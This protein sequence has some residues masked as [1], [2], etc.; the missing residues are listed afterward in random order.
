M[1]A[2]ISMPVPVKDREVKPNTAASAVGFAAIVD[3]AA[4]PSGF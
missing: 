4:L 1:M 3:S 2:A